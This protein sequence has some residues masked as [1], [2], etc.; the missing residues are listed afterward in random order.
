ME[1]MISN[2]EDFCKALGLPYRVVNIVSGE[3]NNAAAKKLDLEAYFPGSGDFFSILAFF[4]SRLLSL[5][6]FFLFSLYP[7][8]SRLFY[9]IMWIMNYF[10]HI[11]I[12]NFFVFMSRI[13]YIFSSL[14]FFSPILMWIWCDF[15]CPLALHHCFDFFSIAAYRELVSC[16]NCLDYQ[17]RRLK[18]R[19]GATKKMNTAVSALQR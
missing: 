19:Y 6:P 8:C 2:A 11:F 10:I 1:E 9:R 3:L 4:L 17:S 7:Y 18:V 15:P 16:S 14:F 13:W 12:N 5:F